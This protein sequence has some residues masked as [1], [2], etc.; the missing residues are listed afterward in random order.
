[1]CVSPKSSKELLAHIF[2]NLKR[3]LDVIFMNSYN[4]KMNF[5]LQNEWSSL[6]HNKSIDISDKMASCKKLIN[7]LKI[8]VAKKMVKEQQSDD[9]HSQIQKLKTKVKTLES[10]TEKLLMENLSRIQKKQNERVIENRQQLE[11]KKFSRYK[12]NL[13]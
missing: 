5:Q 6:Q 9:S 10:Q 12:K 3:L 7:D 4:K 11:Q 8:D 13:V 1:M 2:K